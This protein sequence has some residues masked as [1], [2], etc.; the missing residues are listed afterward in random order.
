[1]IRS[2]VA[3]AAAI[4]VAVSVSGATERPAEPIRTAVPSPHFGTV[5]SGPFSSASVRARYRPLGPEAPAWARRL[6]RRSVRVLIALSDPHS[7]ALIAGER[8]GWDYVWPRDAAAGAIALEA[9]GLHPEA[10][11]VVEFLS[12]LDFDDA[13]RFYPDGS[14]VPGRTAAGDGEG[15]IEAAELAVRSGS[16]WTVLPKAARSRLEQDSP[17][18]WR[19]RQDYGE[20]VTGDLIG[21][22]IA[23][24]A[25]GAEIR[26]EFLTPRGLVREEDADELDSA[27][28]WAV[29]LFPSRVLREAARQ[30]LL[31]L[32]RESTPYGIPPIEGWTP[33]EVWTAPTAWS[34]WALV[35]LGELR[36]ADRLLSELHRAETPQGTLPER[37]DARTGAPTSTTPLGWSHAFAILALRARYP[38]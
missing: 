1:V 36:A 21:N 24:G 25:S 33:G 23:A 18:E 4:L 13:A 10:Q 6:Y 31:E 27:A 19:D 38:G 9:A 32:T 17:T 20:N 3:I 30:T 12:G 2:L 14:P 22:A 26:A 7:G 15:W 34:A 37:V 28:A 35:E 8:D 29:T 11:R 16:G 5:P